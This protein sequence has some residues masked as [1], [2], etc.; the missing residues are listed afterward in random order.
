[1]FKQKPKF[2]ERRKAPPRV[3]DHMAE[4]QAGM[5]SLPR[6]CMVTNIS[7]TGARLFTEILDVPERFTLSITGE[8]V[9][10]RHECR[11][12]WRLGGELGAGARPGQARM[13]LAASSSR[14]TSSA[15]SAN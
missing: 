1:M 6:Q 15:S 9:I 12:V 11:L 13:A 5:G 8:G 14:R 4:F 2:K 10:Y 7:G 3:I